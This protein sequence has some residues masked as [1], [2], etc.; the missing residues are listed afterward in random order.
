MPCSSATRSSVT[1]TSVR[2]R[3]STTRRWGD[4]FMLW[5]PY[6]PTAR[7]TRLSPRTPWLYFHRDHPLK[8]DVRHRA[9]QRQEERRR[10]REKM[11]DRLLHQIGNSDSEEEI[12]E[13]LRELASI[14]E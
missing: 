3:R 4:S 8:G 1:A 9:V 11:E 7:R 6:R 12:E 13:L 10:R 14:G 2:R 5:P